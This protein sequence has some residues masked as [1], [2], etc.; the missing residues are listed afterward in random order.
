MAL[1]LYILQSTDEDIA[2][3][4]EIINTWFAEMKLP[5]EEF[6]WVSARFK[7]PYGIEH[8]LARL[9]LN[10]GLDPSEFSVFYVCAL[11]LFRV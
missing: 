6:G 5:I 2:L 7:K 1:D 3:R 11:G 8:N 9:K 10:D 4:R